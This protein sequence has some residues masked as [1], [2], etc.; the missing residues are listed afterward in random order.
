MDDLTD[1]NYLDLHV[2]PFTAEE[3][4][5]IRREA[6]PPPVAYIWSQELQD[7]ADRLPANLGRSSMVHELVK[8]FDLLQVNPGSPSTDESVENKPPSDKESDVGEVTKS[9][10]R[11]IIVSPDLE[12][13]SAEALQR[14]HDADYVG[15]SAAKSLVA[16][17]RLSSLLDYLMKSYVEDESDDD[18]VSQSSTPSSDSASGRPAKRQRRDIHGL[19]H[20]S[21]SRVEANV[22]LICPRIVLRSPSYRPTLR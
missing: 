3:L 7:A 4:E 19:E 16:G 11:A 14:Y 22:T 12:L 13:G 15:M 9:A 8:S 1:P 20:V 17:G 6:N 10:E 2:V 5:E 18:E 21:E